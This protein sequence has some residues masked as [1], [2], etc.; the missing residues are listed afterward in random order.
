LEELLSQPPGGQPP[1]RGHDLGRKE[2]PKHRSGYKVRLGDAMQALPASCALDLSEGPT[3][4][5]SDQDCFRILLLTYRERL[6]N[7]GPDGI[8]E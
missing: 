5:P 4:A 3:T 6:G 7:V 2:L 8:T 1:R